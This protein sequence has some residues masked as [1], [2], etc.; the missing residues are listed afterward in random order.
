[1]HENIEDLTHLKKLDSSTVLQC[2]QSRYKQK[3][4]Y[5]WA[6]PTLV[7]LNPLKDVP[8]LYSKRMMHLFAHES[9]T[10]KTP[11]IFALGQRTL[12]HLQWGLGKTHQAIVVN[13]E[14]GAG[15]TCNAL[16]LLS[17]LA[18]METNNNEVPNSSNIEVLLCQS[19]PL[20]EAL[21]NAQ[22]LKNENSSRFG[23]LIRLVYLGEGA[24]TQLVSAHIET[25]LLESTRVA[26]QA[27]GERNFHI[28][29]QMLAGLSDSLKTELELKDVPIW[30]IA[31]ERDCN[32]VDEAQFHAT[33]AALEKLSLED[34]ANQL[35][36]LLAAL[37]HLGNIKFTVTQE[38]WTTNQRHHL[39]SAARLLGL[40]S[41]ELFQVFTVRNFQA[42]TKSPAVVRP[43]SSQNE[44]AARRDT[45]IKL[46]YRMM[47]DTVLESVNEKLQHTNN[48]QG[49]GHLFTPKYLCILDLYGFESF[50]YG[51]SLEQL[52]INYA[53]ERLQYYFTINYLKEQQVHLANEGLN[54]IDLDENVLDKHNLISF[55]DGPVSVFGVLNEECYLNRGC[56]DSQV[57][58]RIQSSLNERTKGVRS[59][60]PSPRMPRVSRT[61]A[62]PVEFAIS[63]YAG[64]V[65]YSTVAMLDKN[66]DQVPGE[67]M[68]LLS[69]SKSPFIKLLLGKDAL[70]FN[71]THTMNG[72]RH[73]V[74]AKFKNSLDNLMRILNACDVHYVRCIRPSVSEIHYTSSPSQRWDQDYVDAQL[75]ACGVIDTIKVS[76]FGYPIRMSHEEFATRYQYLSSSRRDR[77]LDAKE[78]CRRI[79]ENYP[80]MASEVRVGNSQMYATEKG[81]EMAERWKLQVRNQAASIVQ[82]WW[83]EHLRRQKAAVTIQNWWRTI[84]V[85]RAANKVKRWWKRKRS[86]AQLLLKVGQISNSVR[87]VQRTVR[88]WL[89]RVRARRAIRQLRA[90]ISCPPPVA[91]IDENWCD[92]N[93]TLK[94][95]SLNWAENNNCAKPTQ[96]PSLISLQLSRLNYFYSVGVISIR[97]PPS[98]RAR[99][100]T[101][102]TC[103]PFSFIPPKTQ[104]P[105]GLTDAYL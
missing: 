7:A 100:I 103:L 82:R 73:T 63:H 60:P 29:Y 21:G 36:K 72:R 84:V 28:F 9:F 20:L 51:N 55:L 86:A 67:M 79:S 43:C 48:D 46:L 74:L 44:C 85:V 10:Y 96:S 2:L 105:T 68:S 101:R 97:R 3:Q 83:R 93:A 41:N 13:G 76:S 64:L 56:D 90:Q 77:N 15:K 30:E 6:G 52:C 65:S 17:F 50:Q 16:Y 80:Q 87:V 54:S 27:A 47:F 78:I 37:L 22:T 102:K 45:L 70:I 53:N 31:S 88:R 58:I 89:A 8:D 11:H 71:A 34:T 25:Y 39:E 19:N 5:T 99:F 32:A 104:L 12:R 38:T 1:M 26:R 40:N 81:I 95:V 62:P 14:S 66:R 42:G 92:S 59:M 75:K 33:V 49:Q 24:S 18:A 61:K 4:F 69:K 91:Q 57:C 94:V 23:K 98:V 35:W